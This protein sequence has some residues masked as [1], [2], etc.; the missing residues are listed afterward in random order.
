MFGSADFWDKYPHDFQNVE[1][2]LVLLGEFQNF[3]KSHV[4]M[5]V[6]P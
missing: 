4:G 5:G 2:A 3:Q 6:H 1:I